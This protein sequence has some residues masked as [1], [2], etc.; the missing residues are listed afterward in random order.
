MGSFQIFMKIHGDIYYF[1]FVA[2]VDDNGDKLVT[3]A[4]NTGDNYASVV[5]TGGKVLPVSYFHQ[6]HDT[7]AIINRR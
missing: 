6:F 3:G 7:C 5:V 2:G 4:N 1:V